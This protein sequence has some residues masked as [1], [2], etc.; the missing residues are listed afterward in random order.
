M[1]ATQTPEPG[2]APLIA[3]GCLG[4]GHGPLLRVVF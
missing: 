2:N 4:R 1:A 3:D